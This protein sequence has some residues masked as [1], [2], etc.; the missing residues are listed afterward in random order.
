VK[1]E[2]TTAARGARFSEAA[3]GY[4][5]AGWSLVR[6][7]GKV[8][9]SRDWQKAEPDPDPEHVA[10]L[11]RVWGERWNVGVVL[12]PSG[13]AVVEP[14]TEAAHETL[15]ELLGGRLPAVPVVRSGGRSLHLYFRDDG[16]K[17]ASRDG[18]ELRAGNQQCA[19]PPSRHPSG[20]EYEWLPRHELGRADVELVPVPEAVRAYFAA[21]NGAAAGP[22][23]AVIPVGRRHKELLRLAI[24]MSR[25]GANEKEVGVALL[26]ANGR[27]EIP[28][29][30]EEVAKLARDCAFRYRP[31]GAD[32]ELRE[33]ADAILARNRCAA[34]GAAPAEKP[35]RRQREVLSRRLST[36][37]A[38]RI[39]LL[40]GKLP[41]SAFGA[42][43][44]IGGL[45]KTSVGLAWA[46]EVTRAGGDVLW[47][48]YEDTAEYVLRPR[49]EALGAELERVHE[50]RLDPADGLI[51]FP[52][53]LEEVERKAR[54][55]G[56]RLLVVDPLAAALD[57]KLD[58]HK[59]RDVR[60]VIAGLAALADRRA[61]AAVG[62][63][64][65][66]KVASTDA[67]LRVSG[68]I[69]TYNAARALWTLTPD[70]EEPDALRLLAQHKANW[71]ALAPVERWRV[72]PVTLDG[73]IET[74]VR[75]FVEIAE[76]VSRDDVLAP[77]AGVEKRAEAETLIAAELA[78]GPRPSADVKAAGAR[79]G[80]SERTVKR[81]AQELGVEVEQ[82][83]TSTG[84]AT[85]WAPPEGVGP[86]LNTQVGPTPSDRMETANP[87]RSGH[88]SD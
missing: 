82:R 11:W 4:A 6:L 27:A 53:D 67:Y 49:L 56:A 61:L 33:K 29:D 13:L 3:R 17:P 44:G 78:L 40:I 8:P 1:A 45:G 85:Y 57:L 18:L 34:D 12:G 28:L 15:L 10:G 21:S 51:S 68:S 14:D 80:I 87:G 70:P 58:S 42:V 41:L 2:P 72:K 64:H 39:E 24:A 62:I 63:T 30:P 59:D 65:L 60:V 50:L 31:D 74:A 7:D 35:K 88:E 19:L 43:V 38:R 37:T 83:S 23:P 71:T 79:R 69:A 25:Q 76:D 48:S 32:V 66:N 26:T 16:V 52:R 36:V 46:A 86:V 9:R 55:T 22:L 73:G 47:I 84:R 5:A 54:E 77:A 20:R 75:E 81:A